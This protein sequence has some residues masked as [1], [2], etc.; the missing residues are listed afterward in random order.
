MV[1]QTESARSF[2]TRREATPM[3][4]KLDFE[5]QARRAYSIMGSI[6]NVDVGICIVTVIT[7]I[8]TLWPVL[9]TG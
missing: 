6:Q 5:E 7:V 2:G 1:H 9:S 8:P 3:D 4:R